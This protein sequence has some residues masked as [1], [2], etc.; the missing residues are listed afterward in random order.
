MNQKK[1]KKNK[2]RDGLDEFELEA[3]MESGEFDAVMSEI[4]RIDDEAKKKGAYIFHPDKY[5]QYM[6]MVKL[7]KK[8]EETEPEYKMEYNIGLPLMGAGITIRGCLLCFDEENKL[9]ETLKEI[10]NL[11]DSFWVGAESENSTYIEI[12]VIGVFTFHIDEDSAR[13]ILNGTP[14]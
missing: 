5:L 1:Q 13:D 3:A 2:E 12:T 6:K 9:Y 10:L 11:A 4:K 8:I 7:A 14:E